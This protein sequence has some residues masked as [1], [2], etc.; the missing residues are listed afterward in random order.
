LI[1]TTVQ[2]KNITYPTDAKLAIK[3][4][5]SEWKRFD[6]VDIGLD[7]VNIFFKQNDQEIR[8]ILAKVG[9]FVYGYC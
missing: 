2:E 6:W 1:D 9:W 5:S 8:G 3:I 7:L 4:K